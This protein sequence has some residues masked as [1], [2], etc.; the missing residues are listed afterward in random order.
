MMVFFVR[1]SS[2]VT[3]ELK[4]THAHQPGGSR[5]AIGVVESGD[6]RG[7][8]SRYVHL[9]RIMAPTFTPLLS[10]HDALHTVYTNPSLV[11][12]VGFREEQRKAPVE[13]RTRASLSLPLRLAVAAPAAMLY[14]EDVFQTA[15]CRRVDFEPISYDKLHVQY[16]LH[17]C[18]PFLVCRRASTRENERLLSC[19]EETAQ[20]SLSLRA[21]SPAVAEIADRTA[22]S[23]LI[24]DHLDSNTV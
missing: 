13:Y 18:F 1:S 22:Y 24:N 8:L 4:S 21:R 7:R 16:T 2:Q 20:L 17:D 23:T 10:C 12:L 19:R 11:E 15:R 6:F 9:S 14:T 3:E 5:A